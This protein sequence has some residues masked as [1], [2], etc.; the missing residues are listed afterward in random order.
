[1]MTANTMTKA[2]R[3]LRELRERQ[4]KERQRMAELAVADNLTDE[5]RA[6]LDT[7]EQG[8]PDIERQIRAATVAVEDEEA[9]QHAAAKNG[10]DAD[11]EDGE[12]RERAELR[13]KVRLGGYITAAIEQR[14]AADAEAEY[15]GALG[16]VG[17]RFPLELLATG[18]AS[19]A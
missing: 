13:K 2:Q 1:M 7:I 19:I 9:E 4:S 17:N 18:K 3:T 14:A 11:L 12:S 8:I 10:E 5:T 6:E 15:N 16:I